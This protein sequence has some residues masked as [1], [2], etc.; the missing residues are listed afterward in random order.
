[1]LQQTKTPIIDRLLWWLNIFA[2][3]GLL[4]SYA[5]AF[6]NPTVIWWLA[7]FGL[8]YGIL[9]LFN[10][11]FIAYWLLRLNKKFIF[12]LFVI[13]C[14]IGKIFGIVEPNFSKADSE[15]FQKEKGRIKIMSFNVRLFDLYNWFHSSRTRKS[16]FEFLQNENPD[17]ICFQEF[18]SQDG[19]TLNNQ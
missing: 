4:L 2:V 14:G 15:E 13:V 7:L 5:A 8:G 18:F 12:S 11:L 16:I 10:L 1:M 6:I 17:I 19:K 9:L 3:V